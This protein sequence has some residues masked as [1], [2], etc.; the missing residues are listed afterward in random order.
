MQVL[1]VKSII[2]KL[3]IHRTTKFRYR[4]RYWGQ[5]IDRD[6]YGKGNR[7]DSYEWM[8]VQNGK[9]KWRGKG[10]MGPRKGM[11]GKIAKN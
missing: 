11:Q 4:A 6:P 10:K 3:K 7:I 9:I 1:A 2:T 8:E 5:R